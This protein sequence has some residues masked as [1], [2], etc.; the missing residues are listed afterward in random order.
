MILL[1]FQIVLNFVE[2]ANTII[3]EAAPHLDVPTTMFHR[4]FNTR[5]YKLLILSTSNITAPLVSVYFEFGFIRKKNIF[6]IFFSVTFEF[7]SL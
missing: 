3:T 4:R 7:S 2:I 1:L 5:T 6:P